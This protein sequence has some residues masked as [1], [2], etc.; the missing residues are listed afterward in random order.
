M[1]AVIVGLFMV[2]HGLVHLLYVAQS[3]R[4]FELRADMAWPDRSWAF[5]KPLGDETTRLLASIAYVVAAAAFV[6]GGTAL[7][8]RQE[9]WRPVVVSSAAF[10]AV[11][12]ILF[13]DG[14]L[15]RLRDQ[16]GVGPVIDVAILVA[17]PIL[18]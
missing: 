3:R 18:R 17:V 15:K 11:I 13:W 1:F 5:S 6:A 14:G 7:L 2:L 9:W 4:L 16:G 12:I 10:S 8:L